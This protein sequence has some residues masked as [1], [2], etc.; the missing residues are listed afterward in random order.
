MKLRYKHAVVS[1]CPDLTDPDG[2]SIPVGV[3][4]IGRSDEL[5][6]A[7][8]TALRSHA[9]A[10]TGLLDPISAAI[11][12][13]LL[14]VLQEHVNEAI[15]AEHGRVDPGR[16][17]ATLQGALRNSLFV[18]RI[19]EE[20]TEALPASDEAQS[21]AIGAVVRVL[22]R[23]LE[24]CAADLR[25]RAKAVHEEPA[26]LLEP[27]PGEFPARFWPLEGT[28]RDSQPHC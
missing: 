27:A 1:F 14:G 9:L 26:Y 4:L 24:T 2:Y 25:A 18:S 13:D 6:V 21:F 28:A 17:L 19:S 23:S 16:V 20:Q 5:G 10:K 8:A 3:L 22:T 15:E 12:D 11:Q 7:A